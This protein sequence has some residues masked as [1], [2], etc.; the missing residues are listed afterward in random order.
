MAIRLGA[1]AFGCTRA[2]CDS[3]TAAGTRTIMHA[4]SAT[5]RASATLGAA[6]F[7]YGVASGRQCWQLTLLRLNQRNVDMCGV[8]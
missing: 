7:V 2:E 4:E 6:L 5:A 3:L 1:I 8:L